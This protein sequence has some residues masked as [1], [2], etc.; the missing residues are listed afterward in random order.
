MLVL[1]GAPG[2]L[3]LS[4]NPLYDDES[5]VWDAALL[6]QWSDPDDNVTLEIQKGEWRSYKVHYEH[7][8]ETG[9][10]TGYLTEIKGTWYLDVMPARGEDRGSF[11]VP[12]HAALRVQIEN[13]T[14]E[15]IPLSYDWFFERVRSAKGIQ[16]LAAALDQKQ[17]VLLA[18]A[19]SRVI[20]LRPEFTS[21]TLVPARS[22]TTPLKMRDASR[23]VHGSRRD[24]F[25]PVTKSAP[26]SMRATSFG[27]SSGTSWRSESRVT[28]TRPLASAKPAASA[29]VLPEWRRR[30]R[31]TTAASWAAIARSRASDPS[32]LPSF[33]KTIS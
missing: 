4:L 33:T 13:D 23:R 19:T 11:L 9:D 21:R 3:V 12:V 25:R 15:M 29:A 22:E 14:L 1:A 17:N 24:R 26:S 32:R 10:L 5:I 30:S 31:T 28:R 7:P 8:I 16:P 6:G 20:T 2:C 18:A 27:I